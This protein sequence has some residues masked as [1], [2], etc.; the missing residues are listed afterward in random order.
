MPVIHGEITAGRPVLVHCHAGKDR[1]GV[2]LASYLMR[3]EGLAPEDAIS[4]LRVL[5]SNVMSAPGYEETARYFGALECGRPGDR[6]VWVA[7]DWT[8]SPDDDFWAPSVPK[9][10]QDWPAADS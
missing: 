6:P 3:Y 8:P 9:P 1:T 5:R 10:M 7:P 4:Y 2:M